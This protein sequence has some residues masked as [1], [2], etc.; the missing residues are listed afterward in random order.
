MQT[1]DA[2]TEVTGGELVI[3]A[4][5]SLGIRH[6]FGVPGGQTLAIN[7]AIID[8]DDITFVTARHEGAAAVMADAVGRLSGQPGVCLATTGPGATNLLTGVGGA[9]R[10]SAP[11]IVI[12]CNNRLPDLGR[13]DA[14]AADHVAIFST[15]TKWQLQVADTKSI[16]RAIHEAAIRAASGTPGPVLLDFVRGA[17][18]GKVSVEDLDY[19]F[20]GDAV[21]RQVP[22]ARTLS[23]PAVVSAAADE[24]AAAKRP[25]IWIGNGVQ[26]SGAVDAVT[27]L[28]ETLNAPVITT[29]NAIGAMDSALP[30]SFGPLSRM[31]TSVSR[32]IIAEADLVIAIGNSLNAISTSRWSV[33]PPRIVQIDSDPNII[34]VN[35]PRIT[36]G[37]TGDAR[38]VVGQLSELLKASPE[39]AAASTA[40]DGWLDSLRELKQ[41]FWE[42]ARLRRSG[43]CPDVADRA[44]ERTA[45]GDPRRRHHRGRRGQ[46]GRVVPHVE[47]AQGRS[48]HQAGRLR[49]HG[50]RPAGRD[51]REDHR[52]RPRG[53]RMALGTGRSA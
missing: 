3:D 35:Y 41:A 21:I 36:T 53:H 43:R 28:A 27:E 8:H 19:P 38:S 16:P 23:D 10:D 32:E 4:L 1:I 24:I 52:A 47:R 22:G 50:L 11:V 20:T 5:R 42:G 31:G 6:I 44:D 12:T 29:F 30:H 48:V 34:G 15:L 46:P 13:D 7:D 37:V 17:L 14:Q 33:K 2:K 18:E 49:Q 26:I 40:R 45:R 25:V 51:R 39:I 9:L